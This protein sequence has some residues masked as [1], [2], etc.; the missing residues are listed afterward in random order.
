M[1]T[2]KDIIFKQH[3]VGKGSIQGLLMLDNGIELSVVAGTGMYS[4]GKNGVREAVDN[5]KDVSSF[6][7]AVF[8]QDGEFIG[9]DMVLGWQS[10]EDINELIKKFS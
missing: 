8:D 10:R 1:K 7:V 5:V 9:G 3:K 2:F 4:A 6:E